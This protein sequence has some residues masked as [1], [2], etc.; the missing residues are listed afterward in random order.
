[1]SIIKLREAGAEV[2]IGP[3]LSIMTKAELSTHLGRRNTCSFGNSV[4]LIKLAKKTLYCPV[5]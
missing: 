5:A 1:M 2:L 4:R 3:E